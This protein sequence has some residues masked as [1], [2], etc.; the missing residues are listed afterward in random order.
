M[1]RIGG[2]AKSRSLHAVIIRI[3]RVLDG[4]LLNELRELLNDLRMALRG[5]DMKRSR[6]HHGGDTKFM[7]KSA[8]KIQQLPKLARVVELAER[9]LNDLRIALPSG[10]AN[11]SPMIGVLAPVNLVLI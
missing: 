10:D 9:L 1:A 7:M 5:G 2:V 4:E 6:A 11:L 3:T 8:T